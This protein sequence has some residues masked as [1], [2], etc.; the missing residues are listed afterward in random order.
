M[1]SFDSY[2]QKIIL[3]SYLTVFRAQRAEIFFLH[4]RINFFCQF[5]ISGYIKMEKNFALLVGFPKLIFEWTL[6]FDQS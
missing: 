5:E 6:Q 4:L 1:S 3:L 2:R